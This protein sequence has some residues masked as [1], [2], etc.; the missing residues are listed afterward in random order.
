MNRREFL[1]S[2][3]AFVAAAAFC[4]ITQLQEQTKTYCSDECAKA[5]AKCTCREEI[6]AGLISPTGGWCEFCWDR[7]NSNVAPSSTGP[8][9]SD[10]RERC[11]C[12]KLAG[13]SGG[14]CVYCLNRG[15]FILEHSY[16]PVT[17]PETVSIRRDGLLPDWYPRP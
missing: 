4:G 16:V 8:P 5:D 6:E 14:I 15:R 1:K 9:E 13:A 11:I 3:G 17:P 10:W 2:G 12:E 7:L